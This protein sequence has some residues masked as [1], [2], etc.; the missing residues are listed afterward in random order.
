MPK[1]HLVMGRTLDNKTRRGKN[2]AWILRNGWRIRRRGDMK[3]PRCTRAIDIAQ[4]IR[5]K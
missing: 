5:E 4:G 1:R 2:A 3:L